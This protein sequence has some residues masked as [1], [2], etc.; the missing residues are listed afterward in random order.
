MEVNEPQ[1]ICAPRLPTKTIIGHVFPGA[2]LPYGMFQYVRKRLG[3]LHVLI[4]CQGMA[5]AVADADNRGEIAA[6]FV[7]DNS[8]IQGFSHLHD[9]GI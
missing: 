5:K 1:L 9:S 3:C 7:S 2:T 4:S 6:G 8:K